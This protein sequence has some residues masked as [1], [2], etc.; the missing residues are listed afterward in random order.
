MKSIDFV[1]LET[2]Q[3]AY[4]GPEADLWELIMGE[5]IHVG[6][7][8]SSTDLAKKA[9]IRAGMRGV[10][11]CCCTG[12]GMRFLL[13]FCNVAS[14]T[15][16]DAT[17]Y[18]IERGRERCASEE[19]GSRIR[20]VHADA[21]DSGLPSEQAD[22]VWGED[23]WCYVVEKSRLIK[24]A[25]R[26]IKQGGVLAFTDWI[27]GSRGMD[28]Q[29]AD[30]FLTFMKFPNVQDRDGYVRLLCENS[31]DVLVA[32]DT[33]RFAPYVDLYL[34]MLQLQ[35]GY[36]A[37]RVLAFNQDVVTSLAEEMHFMQ[38][39]AHDHKIAQGL[40]IAKKR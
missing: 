18:M 20:F 10:D 33:G 35:L 24:E 5:Q 1:T 23:A 29:E 21:C 37:L 12:A 25:V 4:S 2:V 40:F 27:E 7:I 6:G 30:R 15:G 32:E 8:I 34:N 3:S 31:C 36:D 14:M 17:E 22:F 26:L 28:D 39:L 11:L 13:R 19:W 38:R 9:D 16:V